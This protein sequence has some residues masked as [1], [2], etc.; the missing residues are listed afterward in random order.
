MGEST[1]IVQEA[2]DDPGIKLKGFMYSAAIKACEKG[3]QREKALALFQEAKDDPRIELKALEW[4]QEAKDAPT[5]PLMLGKLF[6]RF[7]K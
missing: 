1:G 7:F 4:F 2:K 3:G 5:L 6:K